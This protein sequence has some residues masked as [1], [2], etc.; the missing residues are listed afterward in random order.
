MR[1]LRQRPSQLYKSRLARSLFKLALVLADMGHAE[2]AQH[3]DEAYELWKEI[4]GGEV[5]VP[6]SEEEWDACLPYV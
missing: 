1:I 3:R 4:N 5:Q 6:E 2:F